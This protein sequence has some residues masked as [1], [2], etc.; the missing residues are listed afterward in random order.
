MGVQGVKLED[1]KK[2]E[3]AL[4]DTLKEVAKNG[5]EERFFETTLH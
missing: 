4:Y 3:Q 2:C 1:V 5:I